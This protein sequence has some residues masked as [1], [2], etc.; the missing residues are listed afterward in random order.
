MRLRLRLKGGCW[1][2]LVVEDERGR[3]QVE[4]FLEALSKDNKAEY[5]K[6]I[7]R[8]ARLADYGR[9]RNEEVF[10][11]LWA[12]LWEVKTTKVRVIAWWQGSNL[13]LLEAFTKRG[14]RIAPPVRERVQEMADRIPWL[15]AEFERGH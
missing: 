11:H 3:C 2:V 15:L 12:D 10:K 5:K 6:L 13:V 1:Q 9:P 8:L 7:A 4:E 14:H